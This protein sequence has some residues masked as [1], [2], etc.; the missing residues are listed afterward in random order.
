MH[1]YVYIR[2]H[3]LPSHRDLTEFYF[4]DL[5]IAYSKL[6]SVNLYHL[7]AIALGGMAFTQKK[8]DVCC[9]TFDTIVFMS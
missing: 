3:F 1:I 7:S 5:R 2:D 9:G 6:V 8:I 4:T